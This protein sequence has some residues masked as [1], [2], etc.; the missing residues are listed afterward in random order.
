MIG[1]RRKQM[2]KRLSAALS[3][4]ALALALVVSACGGA[5]RAAIS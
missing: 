1:K 4:L 5:T 3:L 2:P